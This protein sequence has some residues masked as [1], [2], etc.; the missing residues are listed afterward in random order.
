MTPLERRA[1]VTLSGLFALRMLGLF[2][3]LPVFSLYAHDLRGSTPTLIGLALGAYGLTQAILQIPF[4]IWSDRFGRRPIILFGL[5]MF[6]VG[7]LVAALSD[8]IYG[9]ILGRA[10]QG[11]GSIAAAIMALAADLTREEQ[12]TKA[13][14][15]IGMSI[16]LAFAVA[17]VGGPILAHWIGLSGIF[18]FTAVS[19]VLGITAFQ[20]GI[21]RHLHSQIH[22]DAE[23]DPAQFGD[24]LRDGQLLRLNF[25]IMILQMVLTASFVVLPL[26]LRDIAGLD[27]SKH[28]HVYLPVM[29]LS[30]LFMTPLVIVAE[31]YRR[32]KPIFLGAIA[33]LGLSELGMFELHN[34]LYGLA[35]VLTLFFTAVNLLEATLPSLVSKIAPPDR[36]GTAMGFYST[37]QFFG[38]FLGG[39]L[40][41][42]LHGQQGLGVV[43]MACMAI[44][45]VWFGLAMSMRNPRYLSSHLLRVGVMDEQGARMLV[46]KL[47]AVRGVAEAVV[48]GDEGMA[49]LK[50]DK[51]ALDEQAL[52]EVAGSKTPVVSIGL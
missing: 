46:Q 26:A 20:I 33:A 10:L 40:G 44:T 32:M 29:V 2:L 36:K 3:I 25:G 41:G 35:A 48:I 43:F 37:F 50:V 17:L 49:Y 51:H 42:W 12:R 6:A 22:R 9:V 16:G 11:A 13:M 5:A 15:A 27:A 31:K 30:V 4:G 23:A 8:S 52:A 7:G 1:T 34:S 19:G 24:V 39:M 38:A 28:W 21:P 45:L 18:W 14:A 47:T